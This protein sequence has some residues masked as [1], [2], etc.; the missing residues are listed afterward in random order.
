MCIS[1]LKPGKPRTFLKDKEPVDARGGVSGIHD[2]GCMR[3]G[4]PANHRGR[5][6]SRFQLDE[7]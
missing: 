5:L 6:T 2:K 3:G 4:C 1:Y 7:S